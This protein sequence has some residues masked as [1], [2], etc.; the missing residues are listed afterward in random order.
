[1]RCVQTCAVRASFCGDRG[2]GD[3]AEKGA[4]RLRGKKQLAGLFQDVPGG[5]ADIRE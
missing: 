3:I 1:M 5:E 4:R 2:L